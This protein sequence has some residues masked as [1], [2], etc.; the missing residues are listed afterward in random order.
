MDSRGPPYSVGVNFEFIG[1][2]RSLDNF[3]FKHDDVDLI[4]YNSCS[5][6]VEGSMWIFGGAKP[7]HYNQLLARALILYS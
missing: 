2:P 7:D 5:T 4:I 3:K 6:V 1:A